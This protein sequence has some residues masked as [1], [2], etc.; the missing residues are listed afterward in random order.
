MIA[1][2]SKKRTPSPHWNTTAVKDGWRPR[3]PKVAFWTYKNLAPNWVPRLPK[4]TPRHSETPWQWRTDVLPPC[5]CTWCFL[6]CLLL[7]KLVAVRRR[8]AFV[9]LISFASALLACI[10]PCFLLW[11]AS[12]ALAVCS[13]HSLPLADCN[14]FS[15]ALPP[16]VGG[17][18]GY[19]TISNTI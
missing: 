8:L 18:G 6:P 16:A 10:S 4:R 17:V 3:V 13:H 9:F 2:A 19:L 15:D 7:L 11:S 1:Q 5:S 12:L 14:V